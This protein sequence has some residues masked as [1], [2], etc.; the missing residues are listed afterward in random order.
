MQVSDG[1][2]SVMDTNSVVRS[3]KNFDSRKNSPDS[4]KVSCYILLNLLACFAINNLVKKWFYE[5]R[6]LSSKYRVC[7]LGTTS[8]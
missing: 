7:Q 2:T 5:S 3:M 8:C 6:S 4:K 1:V